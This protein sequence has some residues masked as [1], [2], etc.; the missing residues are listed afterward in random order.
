MK[1]MYE[2]IH[3]MTKD[4]LSPNS[5]PNYVFTKLNNSQHSLV[6]DNLSDWRTSIPNTHRSQL[7]TPSLHTTPTHSRPHSA[8]SEDLSFSLSRS[9][10]SPRRDLH[11]PS[12]RLTST[13]VRLTSTPVKQEDLKT[14]INHGV[15]GG[16][17]QTLFCPQTV[18]RR[19]LTPT[20][21][22]HR[23]SSYNPVVSRDQMAVDLST[24]EESPKIELKQFDEAF[25]KYK[26]RKSRSSRIET[27][28]YFDN[29]LV[30]LSEVTKG[31]D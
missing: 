20:K 14:R 4:R 10:I 27:E 16:V 7:Y 28:K 13:P 25:A 26:E 21:L 1:S 5:L 30:F 2:W 12:V 15:T 6:T 23:H 8:M 18:R 9:S 24:I 17:F 11:S 19:H 22:S 3:L 31:L 29:L